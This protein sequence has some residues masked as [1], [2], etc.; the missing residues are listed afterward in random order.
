MANGK[1]EACYAMCAHDFPCKSVGGPVA[2]ITGNENM[3]IT[4]INLQ[5]NPCNATALPSTDL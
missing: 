3:I 5:T 2:V 1:M 4:T